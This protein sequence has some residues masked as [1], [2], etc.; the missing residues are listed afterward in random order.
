MITLPRHARRLVNYARNRTRY[1][2]QQPV[3]RF[4][5]L[6]REEFSSY[7]AHVE[8]LIRAHVEVLIRINLT[9]WPRPRAGNMSRLAVLNLNRA[10]VGPERAAGMQINQP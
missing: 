2:D 3:I 9:Y 5:K 4:K 7:R 8:V 10:S 6:I 1:S